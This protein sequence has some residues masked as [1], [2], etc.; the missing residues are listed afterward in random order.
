LELNV[1]VSAERK[2]PFVGRTGEDCSLCF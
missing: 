2:P 1:E